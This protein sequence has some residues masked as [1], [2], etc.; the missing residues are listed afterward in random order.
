MTIVR[1][2]PGS[3]RA[4]ATDAQQKFDSMHSDLTALVNDA[5]NVHYAG[6]NAVSF[7]TQ[8]GQMAVDF[9]SSLSK[10]LGSIADAVRTSTT[11]I[12]SSLGGAPISIQVSGKAITAPTPPAGDGSVDVNTEGL[13]GLVPT[14]Q[15]HFGTI[16]ASLDGHLAKLRSTDWTG[17]AKENAVGQVS[18]FTSSAKAKAES[19][20]QALVKYINQQ[21]SDVTAADR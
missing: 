18:G 11:N 8:C 1:V 21:I 6:P 15:S 20:E 19:A 7:K 9:A 10:D 5:V 12:A 14:V 17:N 4:Y 16:R 2:E 13:Q 3:V